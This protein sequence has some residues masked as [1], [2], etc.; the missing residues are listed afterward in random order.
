MHSSIETNHLR[1]FLYS[2]EHRS[3]HILI[4]YIHT[5]LSL[6][7]K[8]NYFWFF[9]CLRFTCQYYH[10][11]SGISQYVCMCGNFLLKFRISENRFRFSIKNYAGD[12]YFRKLYRSTSEDKM[13]D[14]DMPVFENF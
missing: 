11:E 3:S 14:L 5:S 6:F 4:H 9:S 1:S 10:R 12:Q 13:N 2:V 8:G 7:I